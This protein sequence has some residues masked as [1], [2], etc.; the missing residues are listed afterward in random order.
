MRTT[1]LDRRV[2]RWAWMRD[3]GEV[4]KWMDG[5]LIGRQMNRRRD[6]TE[7]VWRMKRW[8]HEWTL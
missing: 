8:L 6:D 1:A 7:E 5:G 3:E 2:G 4:D